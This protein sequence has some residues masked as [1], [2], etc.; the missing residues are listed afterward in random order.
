MDLL[1]FDRRKTWNI[2]HKLLLKQSDNLHKLWIVNQMFRLPTTIVLNMVLLESVDRWL[3]QQKTWHMG[4]SI[5]CAT[6]TD[7]ATAHFQSPA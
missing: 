5:P 3:E 7:I 2:P 6:Q 1:V 4:L